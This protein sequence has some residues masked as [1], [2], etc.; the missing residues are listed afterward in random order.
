MASI[1]LK[2][3]YYSVQIDQEHLTSF[4]MGIHCLSS[5]FFPMVYQ[6]VPGSLQN[7]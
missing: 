2:D 3:A 7:F 1:D 4:V 6:L 5:Q